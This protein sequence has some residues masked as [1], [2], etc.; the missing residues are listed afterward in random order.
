MTAPWPN[1]CGARTQSTYNGMLRRTVR[2]RWRRCLGNCGGRWFW[3]TD[4]LTH[5]MC[6]RCSPHAGDSGGDGGAAPQSAERVVEAMEKPTKHLTRAMRPSSRAVTCNGRR[7][8]SA[9]IAADALGVTALT[10]KQR[11]T[12]GWN[13]WH[14]ADQPE[15]EPTSP[16][17]AELK[18]MRRAAK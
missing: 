4:A 18:R 10:V 12:R 6:D 11:C 9:E 7:F 15:P 8:K 16:T 2:A 5:R 3:S 13:R 17:V 14:W 1:D